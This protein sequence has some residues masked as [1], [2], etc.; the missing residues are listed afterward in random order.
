MYCFHHIV[1]N[2]YLYNKSKRMLLTENR[3]SQVKEKY[4]IPS[5][6]WENYGDW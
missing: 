2:K 5:Q 6:V 4:N 1:I 3:V